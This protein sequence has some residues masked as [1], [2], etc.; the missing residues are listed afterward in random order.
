MVAPANKPDQSKWERVPAY[1][2][3]TYPYKETSLIVEVLTATHG[4]LAMVAKGA[5]RPTS[6][7][8]GLLQPFVPLQLNFSGK[9]EVKTL[10][11]AEWNP[12]RDLLPA[13]SLMSAY[14]VNELVLKLVARD[15]PHGELF[16]AYAQAVHGLADVAAAPTV[17]RRFEVVLLQALGYG[18]N[19][20]ACAD[21]GTVVMPDARYAWLPER[22]IVRDAPA[23]AYGVSGATLL[24]LAGQGPLT[25]ACAHEA[26][27][28]MRHVLDYYL[29]KRALASRQL[30]YDMQAL[31]EVP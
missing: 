17:L 10:T 18:L 14:Y 11:H 8:R 23:S 5:K 24:A 26:K 30:A 21:D 15:D 29:E 1:V 2:L 13:R 20:S 7:L 19:F 16:E 31:L 28:F 4:R 25:G 22:G 6:T 3:H 27:R 12:G 9:G